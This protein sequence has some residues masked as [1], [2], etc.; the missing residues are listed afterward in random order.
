MVAE[1]G[2]VDNGHSVLEM[3]RSSEQNDE[4]ASSREGKAELNAPSSSSFDDDNGRR[5]FL[6]DSNSGPSSSFYDS[7]TFSATRNLPPFHPQLPTLPVSILSRRRRRSS[8]DSS[9]TSS[10]SPP[11]SSR[12][13]LP[14]VT[15]LQHLLTR[16][17]AVSGEEIRRFPC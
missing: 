16:S 1:S 6:L 7:I 13:L 8:S 14:N 5:V 17:I 2:A 10:S 12:S 3:D 15:N 9:Q 11:N 4:G